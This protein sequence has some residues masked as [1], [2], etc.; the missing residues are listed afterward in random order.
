MRITRNYLCF[1]A[2]VFLAQN[3]DSAISHKICD[4]H[5]S[6]VRQ[7]RIWIAMRFF[8]EAKLFLN[9][10]KSLEYS[11]LLLLYGSLQ[12]LAVYR[13]RRICVCVCTCAW[14]DTDFCVRSRCAL[15]RS[16]PFLYRFATDSSH[17]LHF[18]TKLPIPKWRLDIRNQTRCIQFALIY[19]FVFV[20]KVQTVHYTPAGVT[21]STMSFETRLIIASTNFDPHYV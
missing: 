13:S 2:A 18:E 12:P 14:C 21:L 3:Y 4:V 9:L 1:A 8:F 7:K 15:L 5:S 11:F 17:Y 6:M 10:C 20:C 19:I 16:P